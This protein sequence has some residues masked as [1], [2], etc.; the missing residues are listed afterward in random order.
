MRGSVKKRATWQFTVEIGLQPLQR[1]PACKKRYWVQRGGQLK[2]CPRC[3]G[4][5]EDGMERR[6][7]TKTG[8][9]TK[10]EAE[11]ELAKAIGAIVTGNYVTASKL[12]LDEFLRK[13]WLPAIRPTIRPT[14]F[15]SYQT[16]VERHL[17]PELGRFQLQQLNGAQINTFYARLL[18]EE[19]EGNNRQLAPATVRRIHATLHRL[20]RTPSAG[21]GWPVTRRMP[22]TRPGP[23]PVPM[24]RPT[25]GR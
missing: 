24:P 1:C 22:P 9:R 20:S 15:L 19:Q 7:E 10:K 8:F 21:T 2:R 23:R 25:S 6:Q 3:Q 12:R 17:I 18:S 14:T 4:T 5:L 13:E 11:E 16:H